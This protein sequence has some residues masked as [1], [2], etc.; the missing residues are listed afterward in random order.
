MK[1]IAALLLLLCMVCVIWPAAAQEIEIHREEPLFYIVVT[2]PDSARVTQSITDDHFSLT[3]LEFPVTG[4]PV[5][6]ITTAADE[7]FVGQSL[8]DLSQDE[9]QMII[10]DIT[11]EMANPSVDIHS[12]ADGYVY[13]TV[14]ENTQ[15]NDICET[16]MLLNGY[17]IMV[18]VYYPDNSRL[19]DQ[20]EAYGPSIV[21]TLHWVDNTNS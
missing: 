18:H 14:N 1:K 15:E 9:I 11:V 6:V 3:E 20:D 13:I 19:T 12:T 21:E 4:K 10:G 7:L 2:L 5:I 16:V 8:S 17:F